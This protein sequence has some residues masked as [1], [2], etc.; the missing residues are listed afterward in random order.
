VQKADEKIPEDECRPPHSLALYPL[1]A[2]VW[3]SPGI[4]TDRFLLEHGAV[5][6]LQA[7]L[8]AAGIEAIVFA[9]MVPDPTTDAVDAATRFVREG[10]NYCR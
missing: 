4:I 8:E 2:A 7:V 6:R 1:A 10:G 5:A 3:P 9:D